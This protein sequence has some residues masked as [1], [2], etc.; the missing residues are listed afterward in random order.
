MKILLTDITSE[1]CS[2]TIR[3]KVACPSEDITLVDPL[4]AEITVRRCHDGIFVLN[5]SMQANVITKCDRCGGRVSLELDEDFTYTLRLESEPQMA[6][7]YGCSHEDCE[8]LYLAEPFVESDVILQEQLLLA[9]PVHRLC[10][11][12]CRG[13][14]T[15]CGVDLNKE[16]C[17]CAKDNSSSPFAVLRKLK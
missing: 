3:E 14:C 6:K 1:K 12:A 5:G 4:Q 10:N 9:L 13:L 7:E 16:S 17:R 2:F 15:G 8:T 11:E